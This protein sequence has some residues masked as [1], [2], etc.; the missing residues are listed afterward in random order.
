MSVNVFPRGSLFLDE[1]PFVEYVKPCGS[2]RFV[3]FI[4]SSFD[5]VTVFLQANRR[6]RSR[7]IKIAVGSFLSAV[8]LF[9]FQHSVIAPALVSGRAA[10]NRCVDV[11]PL[12]SYRRS[13]CLFRFADDVV[14][15]LL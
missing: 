2:E 1:D 10:C 5:P 9:F 3:A 12:G 13:L 15:L 6:E 11:T 4:V 14:L 7:N 8:G